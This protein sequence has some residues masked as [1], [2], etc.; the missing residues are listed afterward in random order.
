MLREQRT[1]SWTD[2]RSMRF[3]GALRRSPVTYGNQEVL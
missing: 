2:G 3:H 1:D